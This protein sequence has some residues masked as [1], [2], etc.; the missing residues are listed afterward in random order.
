MA[1]LV[2]TMVRSDVG[3]AVAL[4]AASTWVACG[5]SGTGEPIVRDGGGPAVPPSFPVAPAADP[6]A[7]GRA[8][9]PDA[10]ED[11]GDAS[12]VE[13][14]A[15]PPPGNRYRAVPLSDLPNY[16]GSQHNGL[17]CLT[18]Y[19]LAGHAPDGPGPHPLFLYFVGTE[20]VA[21]DPAGAHDGPAP[22]AVTEAMAQRGFVALS[23]D[24]D[25]SAIAWQST[26][27]NQ[28]AC[29]FEATRPDSLSATACGLADVDCSLG[30]ATWGHSQGGL[31]AA[32]AHTYDARV[33]AAWATGYGGDGPVTLDKAR[34][35]LVNGESDAS[36]Q[37]AT[38]D[39]AAG[40]PSSRCTEDADTCLRANGSGWVR[41]RRADLADPAREAGHC[42]FDRNSC[43]ANIIALEPNWIS[44]SSDKPFALS[45]NADWLAATTLAP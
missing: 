38:L 40:F 17:D 4:L 24:Y 10:S 18:P 34:V 23:A 37:K 11:A 8:A 14:D 20:F 13:Q 45:V 42:W 28:L 29:L 44:P 5:T 12:V 15:G 35:R 43:F 21:G 3:A 22:M 16:L 32:A 41:V 36:G 26:H 27:E 2:R 25:N 31:V 9:T 7:G 33:R 39:T 30:I 6:D 19:A 1:K